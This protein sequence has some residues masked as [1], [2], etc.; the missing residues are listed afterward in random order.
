MEKTDNK[1]VS[2]ALEL[3]VDN[4]AVRIA[5]DP[6]AGAAELLA[7]HRQVDTLKAGQRVTDIRLA[8]PGE[9]RGKQPAV[10]VGKNKDVVGLRLALVGLL[11]NGSLDIVQA[12]VRRTKAGGHRVEVLR[13]DY[14][15][16]LLIGTHKAAGTPIADNAWPVNEYNMT[17]DVTNAVIAFCQPDKLKAV[18]VGNAEALAV[19]E[20]QAPAKDEGV[21]VPSFEG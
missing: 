2:A 5:E 14:A 7:L 21:P 20:T 18:L 16:G 13:D 11:H 1:V 3:W 8:A 6:K 10:W 19:L 17:G 15:R 9:M 12:R 4:T